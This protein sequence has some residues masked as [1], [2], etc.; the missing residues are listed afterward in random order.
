MAELQLGMAL[1]MIF[2]GWERKP[3]GMA[4]LEHIIQNKV[5][6]RMTSP[7]Q[8]PPRQSP[9]A[10]GVVRPTAALRVP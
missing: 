3:F 6:D 8:R 1:S 10:V 4:S 5:V 7:G 9:T 2:A